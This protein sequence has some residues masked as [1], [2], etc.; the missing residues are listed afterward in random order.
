ML[1]PLLLAGLVI[2]TAACGSS[3]PKPDRYAVGTYLN[4][5]SMLTGPSDCT[6][7]AP[8]GVLEGSL[9]MKPGTITES[10]P[11]GYKA[12]IIA[13]YADHIALAFPKTAKVGE[14]VYFRFELRDAH[15]E[16]MTPTLSEMG[17]TSLDPSCMALKDLGRSGAQD[18]G[19]SPF[20]S[21]TA[22]AA[23]QCKVSIDIELPAKTGGT[24]KLHG[25]QI[26]V[27]K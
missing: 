25:E 23:G 1:K 14:E 20:M 16:Q 11:S 9:V 4:T 19:R 21:A 5:G 17:E 13:D 18:T 10:C 24:Q 6:F 26:V 2:S 15:N 27:V 3:A 22:A 7:A 8:P 12:T